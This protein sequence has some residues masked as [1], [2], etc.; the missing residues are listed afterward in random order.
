MEDSNLQMP[1]DPSNDGG[2]LIKG[3][4]EKKNYYFSGESIID[5]EYNIPILQSNIDQ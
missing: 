5:L 2:H 3:M 1:Y 4:N